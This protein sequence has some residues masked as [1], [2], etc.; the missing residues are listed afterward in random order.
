MTEP[1]QVQTR[2][3]DEAAASAPEAP[4]FA[5]DDAILDNQFRI[6]LV[7]ILNW[8][9]YAGLH[10][11]P[12]GH[13]GT[14]ILGPTGMGKSTVL[15]AMSSVIMPNPQ[16]FNRAARDDG[17]KKAERTVYSYARGKTDD[18]KDAR[19]DATTTHFLR[20]L[21]TAFPT[22]AAITWR[23]DLGEHVTAVRIAW[24]GPETSSQDDL[25]STTVYMLLEG[26]F[27]LS[28]LS[29]VQPSKG[30]RSP[31]SE[32]ALRALA[33]GPH[34]LVT[35]SQPTL[36]ARLCGRLGIGGSEESQLKALTL[37]RRAQASKGIFSISDLFKEF[38]LNEP[39]ALGRWETTLSAYRE[40]SAL[41]D[42]FEV[43]RKR[44][45]IL[46]DVPQQAERYRSAMEAATEKRRLFA[47]TETEPHSRLDLWHAEKIEGWATSR[48]E[49]NRVDRA[50][51]ERQRSEAA[52][53][54]R[55]AQ[56]R[57][58]SAADQIVALGGDRSKLVKTQLDAAQAA[59]ERVESDR[60][61]F[62]GRLAQ[63]GLGMPENA[64][65]MDDL[66]ATMRAKRESLITERTLD[67]E[68]T[69]QL[70]A[71]VVDLNQQLAK[72][73]RDLDSFKR[74]RSNVPEDADARRRSIAGRRQ[75]AGGDPAL[76]R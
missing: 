59:A 3:G 67:T 49:Q 11:M 25:N 18:V 35:G 61:A 1:H 60:R 33:D 12:V 17:G 29:E 71:R 51:T 63:V 38:V 72:R 76:R 27:S 34:D 4:V 36:R 37:L 23:S 44:L 16:E 8:G 5:G 52:N 9:S 46:A 47:T 6:E 75:G 58:E 65:Q 21:G 20:P 64:S 32:T 54:A 62:A 14:A 56:Q 15:D 57:W 31:L 13:H 55:A 53:D 73:T 28:R 2:P 30:A 39:L 7:Q 22:G 50:E 69:Q 48:I 26:K 19:S 70:A 66:V 42:V 68:Q 74:R 40:A 43:A 41:Y 24:V 10:E 45:D